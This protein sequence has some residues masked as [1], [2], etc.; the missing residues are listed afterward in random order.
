MVG[1]QEFYTGARLIASMPRSSITLHDSITI[2]LTLQKKDTLL[3][4]LP[5]SKAY[6]QM[7][8]GSSQ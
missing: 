4:S 8:S 3:S 2:D 7:V 1:L 6:L 5:T